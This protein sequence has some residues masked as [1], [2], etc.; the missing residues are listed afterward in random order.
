MDANGANQTQITLSTSGGNFV[1]DWSHDGQRIAVAS[2]REGVGHAEVWVMVAD[3]SNPERLTFTPTNPKGFTW[4]LHPSWSP[5]G[6]IVFAS[7]VSG[8][9]EVWIMNADGSNQVQMTDNSN[10]AYPDSY[11][12][13][14]SLPSAW[15]FGLIRGQRIGKMATSEAVNWEMSF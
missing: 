5:D 9:T 12:P 11:V 15:L 13:E 4:S 8:S 2:L 1:P 10:A 3:G 14:W 6:R 7:T